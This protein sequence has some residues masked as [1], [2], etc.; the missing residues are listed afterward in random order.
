[1]L[2]KRGS[3]AVLLVFGCR[4]GSVLLKWERKQEQRGRRIIYTLILSV[5]RFTFDLHC[6]Q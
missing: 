2:F 3:G 1:M 6:I 4:N 5:L